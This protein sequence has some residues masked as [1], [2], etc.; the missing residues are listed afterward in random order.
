MMVS[1]STRVPL[2]PSTLEILDDCTV[3]GH[4]IGQGVAE[5]WQPAELVP[6]SEKAVAD[7]V[8]GLREVAAGSS[9]RLCVRYCRERQSQ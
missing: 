9:R 4:L 7:R 1:C 2:E 5:Q 6:E 8:T 3:D